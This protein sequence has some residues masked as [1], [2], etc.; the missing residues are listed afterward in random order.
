MSDE[1]IAMMEGEMDNLRQKIAFLEQ[2]L[3]E[4]ENDR[5]IP[6][7]RGW[8]VIEPVLPTF[9]VPQFGFKKECP[10]CGLKLTGPIGYYCTNN[11]CPCGLGGVYCGT[12]DLT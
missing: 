11:P 8:D 9:P 5:D 3:K 4:L 7:N 6:K 10:K 1:K 2:K 12:G